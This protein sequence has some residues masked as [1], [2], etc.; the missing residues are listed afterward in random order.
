MNFEQFLPVLVAL[1]ITAI[2]ILIGVLVFQLVTKNRDN[3][4]YED[5]LN[6][7]LEDDDAVIIE[8]TSDMKPTLMQKWNKHWN[9]VFRGSGIARY[10]SNENKAGSD[11]L[12]VS[13]AIILVGSVLTKTIIVGPILAGVVIFGSSFILKTRAN[14]KAEALNLQLPGFLF[15]L[16]ANIQAS[17][18]PERALLKVVDNMPSP[19]YED[20]IVAKN[21][22]LANASFQEALEEL[23]AKTSS[24]DLQF[25]CACMIQASSSG[26]NMEE[27]LVTIQ[28]VIESRRKVADE[29]EKAVKSTQPAIWLSSFVIPGLFLAS[30]F[31]DRSA[32]DF[33]FKDVFSWAALAVVIGLYLLGI[34]LV[35]KAVNKIRDL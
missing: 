9:D 11:M 14:K 25:L 27:Q 35:K 13:M 31:I 17:S 23:S 34:F 19:L 30:Y 21:K 22:I 15:A 12:I 24:K 20:L 7:L 5:L 6:E 4:K 10:N 29:I 16:K 8:S 28:R 2:V 32:R 1:V 3:T 18:T 33:W 26:A